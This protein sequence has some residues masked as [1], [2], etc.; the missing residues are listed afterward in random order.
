MPSPKKVQV[1]EHVDNSW[2]PFNNNGEDDSIG[3]D[4]EEEEKIIPHTKRYLSSV[5]PSC[6]LLCIY[7]DVPLF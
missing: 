2:V 5:S 3:S 6:D 4:L 1:E 7:T